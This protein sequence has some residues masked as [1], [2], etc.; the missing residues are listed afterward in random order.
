MRPGQE[1]Q[2]ESEQHELRADE[3]REE[4]HDVDGLRAV[5]GECRERNGNAG[6]AAERGH[7]DRDDGAQ[8]IQP[9][10]E[11][12][13]V[14]ARDAAPPRANAADGVVVLYLERDGAVAPHALGVRCEPLGLEPQG[15][16][17]RVF[18][19]RRGGA[20]HGAN[21]R[22]DRGCVLRPHVEHS[23]DEGVVSYACAM[24]CTSCVAS[25]PTFVA[26]S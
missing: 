8:A 2:R 14:V 20:R 12:G 18:E 3:Q 16:V 6:N 11:A 1:Q 10:A 25:F 19:Q 17:D 15:H 5:V 13:T 7:R 26:R 4:P 24:R 21:D 9:G 23:R 22:G